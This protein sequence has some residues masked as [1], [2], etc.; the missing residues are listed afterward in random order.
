MVEH[1]TKGLNLTEVAP[2]VKRA[3][4][5]EVTAD[6]QRCGPP[7]QPIHAEKARDDVSQHSDP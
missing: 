6:R 3:T 1:E 2:P 5:V 7:G 4:L